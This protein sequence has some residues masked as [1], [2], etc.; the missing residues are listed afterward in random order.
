MV[1]RSNA[2]PRLVVQLVEH[3]GTPIND[4][5][6]LTGAPERTETGLLRT[7][8]RLDTTGLTAGEYE[9]RLAHY[10]EL[11]GQTAASSCRLRVR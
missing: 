7:M 10:N 2:A 4:R 5:I 11:G 6:Q 8:A 9:I 3:D 1:D